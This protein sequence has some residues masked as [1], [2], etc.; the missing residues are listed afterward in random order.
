MSYIGHAIDSHALTIDIENVL[1]F[2]IYLK[3][4]TE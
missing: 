4:T 2:S 3:L 1:F